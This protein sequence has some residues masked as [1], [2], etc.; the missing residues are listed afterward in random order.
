MVAF[1]LSFTGKVQLIQVPVVENVDRLQSVYDVEYSLAMR[2]LVHPA[3]Q[4]TGVLVGV[5]AGVVSVALGKIVPGVVEA[6]IVL[7]GPIAV[8]TCFRQVHAV[9]LA[10][11][12]SMAPLLGG[13]LLVPSNW[14]VALWAIPAGLLLTFA[15]VRFGQ[16]HA[17][18]EMT[19]READDRELW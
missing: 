14:R 10:F 7:L 17:I 1:V 9:K 13:G 4:W 8:G 11:A 16:S 18:G 3:H 5:A 2:D 12:L 15:L 6:A 19:R